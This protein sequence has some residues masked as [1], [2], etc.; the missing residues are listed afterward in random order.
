[1]DDLFFVYAIYIIVA[2][3]FGLMAGLVI[4]FILGRNDERN[5]KAKTTST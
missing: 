4:G 5:K 1:M 3:L 2:A